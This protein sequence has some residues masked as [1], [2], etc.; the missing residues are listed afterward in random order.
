MGIKYIN[1]DV[2]QK[3][4]EALKVFKEKST[5]DVDQINYQSQLLLLLDDY[6]RMNKKK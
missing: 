4:N 2:D 1:E 5:F 6:I 3:I